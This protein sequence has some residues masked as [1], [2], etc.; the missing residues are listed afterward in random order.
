MAALCL[1]LTAEAQSQNTPALSKKQAILGKVI[2]ATTAQAL[3]GATIKITG[4][5]Q[6][7]VSNNKGEFILNM[8]NGS[9]NLSVSLLGYKTSNISILIPLTAPLII[10]LQLD[11]KN[12]QEV[13][14]VSTGY[15]NIAKE[16]ATGS[17]TLI[18]NKT[19]NRSL[20]INILDRLDGVTSGLTFNRGNT[21]APNSSIEVRGRAT[22]FSDAQ[23][24]I[25]VDNFPYEG[26]LSNINPNDVA[27]ITILKD[28]A[29]A[30]IWGARSGNGVIVIT[31]KKGS[32]NASPKISVN[33]NVSLTGKP[34]LYYRQQ[35]S[36]AEFIEVEDF[37]FDKGRYNNT[38][39]TGYAALSPAVEIF[40]AKR[41][42]NISEADSLRMINKLK[43]TDSRDQIS[44]YGY[45]DWGIHQQYSGSIA[46]GGSSQKYFFSGGYDK[47]QDNTYNNSFNRITLNA[48]N[49]Y[50]FFNNKLEFSSG[51]IYTGSKRKAGPSVV[52][53]PY[54]Y[55]SIV[56][57]SGNPLP[58]V[59]DFRLAY[60]ENAGKGKLLDWTWKP[61]E[62]QHNGYS[63]TISNLTDY[64]INLMLNYNLIKGLNA[65]AAYSFGKG[66]NESNTL[67]ELDSYYTRNLI[68]RFSQIDP[69]TG[70]VTYPLPMGAILN[71]SQNKLTSHNGRIQLNYNKD[72]KKHVLNLLTGYEIR[73]NTTISNSGSMYGYNPDFATNANNTINHTIDYPLFYD[74]S[75]TGRI[76]DPTSQYSSTDRFLSYYF[77]G[78][79]NYD[80]RY[81]ATLSARRDE[82]NLFGVSTNQKGVPLWS[83]GL[84]WS[85]NNE[86]F[87]QLDWL[88]LLKLRTTFGYTGTVNN[89]ISAYLTA[90]LRG[91]G[92]SYKQ[93]FSDIRNPPNPSLQ[94]ERVKNINL[95]VDFGLKQ[96]R[97]SGSIDYWIKKGLDLIGNSPIAAQTGV[98]LF[99]GNSA[100]TL[101]RG[102][103][104]QVKTLNLTGAVTWSTNLLYNFNHSKVTGYKVANGTNANVVSGNW[105]NPLEGY[106][107]YAIF[108]YRY[109]GLDA[110]GN[111]RGYVNGEI[112]SNYTD[113]LNS[114]N[115][116]ELVYSGPAA[117]TSFGNIRNT[118]AYKN[119]ELSFNIIYKLGYYFRRT[120]LSNVDLYAGSGYKIADYHLRWQKPGD[121]LITN[122]PSAIYPVNAARDNLYTYA[123]ILVEKGDHVRL[124]DLRFAYTI[125]KKQWLPIENVN[126]FIYTNNLGI[127]W[128]VNKH[129]VD[130]DY[131]STSGLRPAKTIAFGLSASF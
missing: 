126:L 111:P 103:D 112:S 117:P 101:T 130:P 31:T 77:N 17:F 25:I 128:K 24:L 92:P 93:P 88:P 39:N 85:L 63:S 129:G 125:P 20:G 41:N 115:R 97:I 73:D 44:K 76:S 61:L 54:P 114:G 89:T 19:L 81:M 13:E 83:A 107:F 74:S 118:F 70:A 75:L 69:N 40:L 33:S 105:N 100:N 108:S 49:T 10:A 30:S 22:L 109:A 127:L 96:N 36:S 102:V 59:T 116:D 124:Q 57:E 47:N 131:P 15:Q 60:L 53:T 5:S 52:S 26:E 11:D 106:P 29:A 94:W 68:N 66:M 35:L 90:V 123:D 23:P 91:V 99:R 55:N 37:L 7:L 1:N 3:P 95:G 104:I 98:S 71:S 67:N 9:Y 46:G 79:Y 86:K 121:E 120:S 34:D 45:K 27:T 58:V 82:S 50:Y 4:T 16:R 6:S 28:A 113:I 32:L 62:E 42:G 72:W 87:Y 48:N 119:F 43:T 110:S 12:L 84:S 64:R 122:V 18:D 78:S 65:A 56:D 51:I 38:I 8:A 2:S 21:T 14:I 80:G